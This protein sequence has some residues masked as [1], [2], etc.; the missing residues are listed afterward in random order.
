MHV[1][2]SLTPGEYFRDAYNSTTKGL[3]DVELWVATISMLAGGNWDRFIVE[4]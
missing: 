1:S 3:N 4:I 2:E